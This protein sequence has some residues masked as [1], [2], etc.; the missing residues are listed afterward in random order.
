MKKTNLKATFLFL[1]FAVI[2]C[3]CFTSCGVMRFFVDFESGAP[4]ATEES[5]V[6]EETGGFMDS[7]EKVD[8]ILTEENDNS[9]NDEE[10]IDDVIPP[11]NTADN[12]ESDEKKEVIQQITVVENN[13][14]VEGTQSN[15]AYAAAA[16]IRS[17]VSIYANFSAG[18]SSGSGVIY[19]LDAENGSAFIVTNYHVV[20]YSGGYYQGTISSD[21]DVYL[22][23]MEYDKY[24]IPAQY[25]GGSANY[26]IAVL[27]VENNDILKK[28]AASGSIVA[29]SFANSDDVIP[30]QTAIAIGNAQSFG[31]SVTSGIISVPSEYI[32]LTAVDGRSQVDF[33]VIRVD[34]AIN[35]GKSGGGLFNDSGKL[36]GIVNAKISRTDVENIAYAIPSAVVKG[37][38]DNIIHYCYGTSKTRVMRAVIGIGMDTSEIT[39]TYDTDK[40]VISIVE[41][42]KV[43]SVTA[44]SIADGKLAVGDVI[45][46]IT[47]GQKT[48]KV[49]RLHHIIDALLDARVGDAV[50]I[51]VT[52]AEGQA[53]AVVL[54]ITE[55]CLTEY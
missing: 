50:T 53:R 18:T 48:V 9:S 39:T 49:T 29:A 24:T 28:A 43:S 55:E 21:I 10:I 47:I 30:G 19:E 6:P 38:A 7:T 13:I 15:V 44:E 16:G 51:N 1:T 33:R 2:A 12:T 5:L 35:S 32:R 22:Y 4:A 23:G 36:I 17:A 34:T 45:N 8:E 14:T 20:Y 46:S 31:I 25:I 11:Q 27:Y 37:V 42:L 52:G 26:D 54:V 3:M 41:T 40:A